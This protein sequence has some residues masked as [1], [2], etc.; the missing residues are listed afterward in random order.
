MSGLQSSTRGERG[1]R[2]LMAGAVLAVVS[3][4]AFTVPPALAASAQPARSGD[5][6]VG[7]R[8]HRALARRSAPPRRSR[9]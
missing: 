8:R 1:S 3:A 2:H 5:D 7:H 4:V 6:R 9:S